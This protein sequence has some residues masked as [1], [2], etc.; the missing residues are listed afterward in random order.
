[1]RDPIAAL[2]ARFDVVDVLLSLG[3]VFQQRDEFDSSIDDVTGVLIEQIEEAAL[4]G[5]Q[6]TEHGDLGKKTAEPRILTHAKQANSLCYNSRR[7]AVS[8]FRWSHVF[9][10]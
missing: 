3:D 9:E 2:L 7:V 6:A 1:M 10:A 4:F 8:K 5:H